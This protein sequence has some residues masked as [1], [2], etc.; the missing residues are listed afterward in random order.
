MTQYVVVMTFPNTAEA[1]Q[2]NVQLRNSALVG[3]INSA[4]IVERDDKGVL[5]LTDGTDLEA[6][7]GVAVGGLVGMIVGILGGPLGMLLGW[8]VGAGIG[9]IRDGDRADDQYST[10]DMLGQSIPDGH[11]ALILDTEE[12]DTAPLDHFAADHNATLIRRPA[13]EVQEELEGWED[14]VKAAQ[15]AA[16]EQLKAEKKAARE[17]D[18]V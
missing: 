8:G 6:G 9:A 3:E 15:K 13:A 18:K 4:A 14:A 11:N 1:Y 5:K 10:L 16:R 17:A 12:S 7:S 2:A